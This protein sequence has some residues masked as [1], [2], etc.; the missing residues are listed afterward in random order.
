MKEARLL[1]SKD[2]A[3]IYDILVPGGT[4]IKTGLSDNEIF[5]IIDDNKIQLGDSGEGFGIGETI[6]EIDNIGSTSEKRLP[7]N[8]TTTILEIVDDEHGDKISYGPLAEY[9]RRGG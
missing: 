4:G 5:D 6:T 8:S 3:G 7:D 9:R 1:L 2:I